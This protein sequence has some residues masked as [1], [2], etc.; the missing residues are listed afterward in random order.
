MFEN[1]TTGK[2][3]SVGLAL[4]ISHFAKRGHVVCLPLND[5]QGYD[6]VVD[7]DGLKRIQVKTTSSKS[8][9]KGYV[10]QLK[11]TRVNRTKNR[12]K[13]FD[14]SLS[15]FLFIATEDESLYLMPSIVVHGKSSLCL[16]N[17]KWNQYKV[18]S[19]NANCPVV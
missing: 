12:I 13:P 5:N 2:Q 7:I 6:L 1:M 4:C 11:S 8:D 9:G 14:S 3:G 18:S 16:N 19:E 17:K 10:V 15:D